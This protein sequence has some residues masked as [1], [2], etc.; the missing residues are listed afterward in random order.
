MFKGQE[1]CTVQSFKGKRER[2]TNIIYTLKLKSLYKTKLQS[3]QLIVQISGSI[4]SAKC[5][6]LLYFALI[7][8]RKDPS[9]HVITDPTVFSNCLSVLLL[10]IQGPSFTC[11]FASTKLWHLSLYQRRSL[12]SKDSSFCAA[13]SPICLPF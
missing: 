7:P 3:V 1:L 10:V 13:C 2:Q 6:S 8:Q 4:T 5:H 9:F 11:F 12:S